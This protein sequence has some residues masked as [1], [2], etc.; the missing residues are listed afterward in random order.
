MEAYGASEDFS[1]EVIW[2]VL[3][4]RK[5]KSFQLHSV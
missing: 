2:F 1:A 3:Y 4:F 5:K